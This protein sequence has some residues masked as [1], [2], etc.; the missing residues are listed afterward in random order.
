MTPLVHVVVGGQFGS[1]AKG[2]VCEILTRERLEPGSLHI[3]VGGPN[4]GHTVYDDRGQRFPFRH[5]PVAAVL[6]PEAILYIAPGSEVDFRVLG[7]EIAQCERHGYQVSHRLWISP[8]A[9]VLE[10][11]DILAEQ[12]GEMRQRV[13]STAKGIGAARANRLWRVARTVGQMQDTRPELFRMGEPDWQAFPDVLVEGTQGYGLG[14][15]AGFY[16][17]CTAGDCRNIDFLAQAGIPISA[18]TSTWVVF[19]TYP[20]RVAG[21]SGPLLGETT[22]EELG[23]EPER[24]TVTDLVRRVGSWD[25]ALADAAIRANGGLSWTGEH[26]LRTALMFVDYLDDSWYG[27]EG[28]DDVASNAGIHPEDLPPIMPQA[29]TCMRYVDPEPG[30]SDPRSLLADWWEQ[31]SRTQ[32]DATVAKMDEYGSNDLVEI[33]SMMHRLSKHSPAPRTRAERIELGCFFYLLGKMARATEAI[34]RGEWPSDDTWFDLEVYAK[35]RLDERMAEFPGAER[36]VAILVRAPD[37]PHDPNAVEVHVPALGRQVG[38]LSREHA[39]I[40]APLLDADEPPWRIHATCE[41]D[42]TSPAR[43][44][45]DQLRQDLGREGLTLYAPH[46]AWLAQP[47]FP[48]DIQQINDEALRAASILVVV[49]PRGQASIGV[50]MEIERAA[51]WSIPTVVLADWPRDTSAVLA[52]T[53]LEWVELP[54]FA[55][56]P[57]TDLV[58]LLVQLARQERAQRAHPSTLGVTRGFVQGPGEIPAQGYPSDAGYDLT[59]HLSAPLTLSDGQVAQIQVGVALQLPAG[60]WGLIHG[61]SSAWKNGLQ[62]KSSVIDPGFR[63]ELY[64][65][66]VAL[67]EVTIQPGDRIAQIVPIRVAPTIIWERVKDLEPS[68]RGVD[69]SWF[70]ILMEEICEL[71]AES[72]GTHEFRAELVQVAAMA[73]VTLAAHDAR[74]PEAW[75]APSVSTLKKAAGK[76]WTFASIQRIAEW[77]HGQTGTYID[78][79]STKDQHELEGILTEAAGEG[80]ALASERGTQ[81]HAMFEAYAE[82]KD[83]E[84]AKGLDAASARYQATVVR[85]IG[86]LRPRVALSEFVCLHY[87]LH[88]LGYGGTADA[89]WWIDPAEWPWVDWPEGAQ[90]GYWLVDYKSRKNKHAIYLEEAWQLAAY[91]LAEVWITEGLTGD[92]DDGSREPA[93]R[94][95]PLELQGGLILSITPTSYQFYPVDLNE[96]WEGF[97][98]LHSLWMSKRGGIR[99]NGVQNAWP[100]K[101]AT[102]DQW[103][104]RRIEAIKGRDIR[105]L[106]GPWPEDV[107]K[108]KQQG[109]MPYTDAEVDLLIPA[110]DQA[111]AVLGMAFGDPDPSDV[112]GVLD[113]D[114]APA[115]PIEPTPD[116]MANID[117]GDEM[118]RGAVG[119]QHRFEKL[120]KPQIDWIGSVVEEGNRA[121]VPFGAVEQ[122]PTARRV[123]IARALILACERKIDEESLWACIHSASG[124]IHGWEDSTPI[125][126]ALGVLGWEEASALATMVSMTA[127]AHQ[128]ELT[129]VLEAPEPEAT[130]GMGWTKQALKDECRRRGLPVSGNKKQLIE[131]IYRDRAS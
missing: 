84:E 13:G 48:P 49:W 121:G 29:G 15:H 116:P 6:D 76:D 33:G 12:A 21:N 130:P 25:Q 55:D 117:E 45:L 124:R 7:D 112:W 37:N 115:P 17:H 75:Q 4:A 50:P 39:A 97:E 32:L 103:I 108:P 63:G 57:S 42:A 119:V 9:T 2:H 68:D 113:E 114:Q 23:Q 43:W 1:E 106:L 123:F 79:L 86:E 77:M 24:T 27:L 129:E 74:W 71:A 110:V 40:V 107:K 61:R 38:H 8:H 91:G 53:P 3:R 58:P 66:C 125:G 104:R 59:V 62:V 34:E 60:V 90:A 82:G 126:E 120:S 16:P 11:E 64:V 109:S 14:L 31:S 41:A 69:L 81:V 101:P 35:M 47:P 46:R 28:G 102:R 10:Q 70:D 93:V 131:R 19:R 72:E 22:W 44:F 20:I 100:P 94:S 5:L 36:P 51:R 122:N 80:L 98:R 128:Q 67:R 56:P 65:D 26:Q 85:C 83:P 92:R 87:S 52:A 118:Q 18:R 95:E 88:D 89:V 127:P 54:T 111:E 73:L 30:G 78:T 96:A 105:P 99:G